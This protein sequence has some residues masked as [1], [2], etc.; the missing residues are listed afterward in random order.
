MND[1][2]IEVIDDS[3]TYSSNDFHTPP[4]KKRDAV[5]MAPFKKSIADA[6]TPK[7]SKN[8]ED[9]IHHKEEELRELKRV[10]L[11]KPSSSAVRSNLEEELEDQVRKLKQKISSL[12][13][14][15]DAMEKEKDKEEARHTGRK[16]ELE[17]KL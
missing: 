17:T 15:L 14:D 6:G 11:A 9:M 16:K 4:T 10:L 13:D 2:E 8:V 12:K 3:E 7:G 1:D 5:N